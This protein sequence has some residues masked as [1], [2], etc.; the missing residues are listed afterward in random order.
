MKVELRSDLSTANP[1]DAVTIAAR[2][3]YM[4]ESVVGKSAEEVMEGQEKTQEE[5]IEK[6][7]RRGHFGPFEH[8]QVFFAIEGLSISAE[9]QITRHRHLSFDVQSQRY[10]DFSDADYVTPPT[11]KESDRLND[12]YNLDVEDAFL[13][14]NHLT[15]NGI[16]GEDARFVT[17]LGTAVN[18][19][20]SGNLRSFFHVIDMRH[21]GNAQWEVRNLAEKMLGELRDFAPLSMKM[22]EEYAKG[23]SK[24]AP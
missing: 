21:A 23:S 24:S 20:V 7:I 1:D 18:M 16:P 2:G 19:C 3:D 10:V 15:E 12:I 9:R 17:P 11:V 13:G 8:P 4:E 6:I 5:F 14:Y 22:Y